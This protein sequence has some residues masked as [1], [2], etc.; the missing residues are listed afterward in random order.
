[1]PLV[2]KSG[3]IRRTYRKK[4]NSK[5]PKRVYK[6]VQRSLTKRELHQFRRFASTSHFVD[7]LGN[8]TYIP[9]LAAYTYSFNQ[10]PISSDFATLF[11]RYKINAIVHKFT[12]TI[13]PGAQTAA[14]ADY[15]R[16]YWRRDYDDSNAPGSLNEMRQSG[17]TRSRFMIPGRTISIKLKPAL[18]TDMN[19]G[20]VSKPTWNNWIN[21]E[22]LAITHR[23]LKIAIDSLNNTNYRVKQ[24]VIFYFSCQDTI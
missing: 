3:K 18:L 1:M 23:G 21:C 8:V 2:T 16:L 12:L 20:S 13:D 7:I 11:D 22:D 24:E 19:N 10:M 6:K 15:P 9:F 14:S 4:T 5:V 17:K